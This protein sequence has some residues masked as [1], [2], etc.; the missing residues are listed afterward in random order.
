MSTKKIEN[1]QSFKKMDVIAQRIL[2]RSHNQTK[3]KDAVI[4]VK[5]IGFEQWEKQTDIP[6]RWIPIVK[7]LTEI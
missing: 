1:T 3:I 2:L 5:N 7:E 6:V 4:Q